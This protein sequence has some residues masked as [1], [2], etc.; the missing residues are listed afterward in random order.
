MTDRVVDL[1]EQSRA[2]IDRGLSGGRYSTADEIVREALRLLDDRERRRDALRAAIDEGDAS[3]EPVPLDFEAF[4]ADKL[5]CRP[6]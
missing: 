4:I 2:I 5:G 6:T 1:D 3:G